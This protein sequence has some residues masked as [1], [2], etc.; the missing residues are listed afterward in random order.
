MDRDL[1]PPL[2]LR[3]L[4]GVG[5]ETPLDVCCS[6]RHRRRLFVKVGHVGFRLEARGSGRYM[7]VWGTQFTV[8]CECGEYVS[9]L[10]DGTL[11]RGVVTWRPM[12]N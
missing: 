6:K 1:L 12:L 4:A 9:L 8:S 10:P 7:W 5:A 11:K 3:E 2:E